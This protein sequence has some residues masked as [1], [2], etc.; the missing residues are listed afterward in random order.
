MSLFGLFGKRALPFFTG[1]LFSNILTLPLRGQHSAKDTTVTKEKP[2]KSR[3][4]SPFVYF[5]VSHDLLGKS[6]ARVTNGV[7]FVVRLFPVIYGR[8]GKRKA[9]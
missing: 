8:T 2:M 1:L 9:N 4:F 3:L 6:R 7:P 5:A